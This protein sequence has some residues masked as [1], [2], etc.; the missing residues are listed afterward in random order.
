MAPE[1][2][3][4]HTCNPTAEQPIPN[5]KSTDTSAVNQLIIRVVVSTANLHT[6]TLAPVEVIAENGEMGDRRN[7]GERDR[8]NRG[9]GP[10][11]DGQCNGCDK[12]FELL[13]AWKESFTRRT[14]SANEK[15]D[16]R[17]RTLRIE[18]E[19]MAEELGRV[20]RRLHEYT[21]PPNSTDPGRG[22]VDK[23]SKP[24]SVT[25]TRDKAERTKVRERSVAKQNNRDIRP[26]AASYAGPAPTRDAEQSGAR[27][28]TVQ[29]ENPASKPPKP[30]STQEAE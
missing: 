2:A 9:D 10:P 8:Q 4:S 1:R 24:A 25:T 18:N 12:K 29:R 6:G 19:M 16:E 26:R 5:P 7:R 13:E 20:R 3:H 30:K 22:D 14:Q 15:M 27:P 28:K 21:N 17:F 23:E 11:K